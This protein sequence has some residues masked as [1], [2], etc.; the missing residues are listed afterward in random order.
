MLFVQ[1][2]I[3]LK[4]QVT[5]WQRP[6]GG[7]SLQRKMISQGCKFIVRDTIHLAPGQIKQIEAAVDGCRT[8]LP[9]TF[10]PEE[11]QIKRDM[12]PNQLLPYQ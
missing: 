5:V 1:F 2:A 6:V 10:R 3:E 12:V 11:L 9:L 7:S 8:P 4:R